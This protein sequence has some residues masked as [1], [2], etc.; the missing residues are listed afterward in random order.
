MR[1]ENDNTIENYFDCVTLLKS[2]PL[3][4]ERSTSKNIDLKPKCLLN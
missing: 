3:M 2:N 1:N 4:N